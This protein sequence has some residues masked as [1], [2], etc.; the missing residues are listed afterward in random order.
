MT[1]LHI[2]SL[3][4]LALLLLLVEPHSPSTTKAAI[5]RVATL[6]T[7][8]AAHT[9]TTLPSGHVLFVGGMVSGGSSGATAE[10]FDPTTNSVEAV[11]S[12]AESRAGHT[13]TQL[14]NGKVLVAGGYN[15]DY[16][17]SIELFDPSTRRFTPAGS[18]T[19]A[20][21]GHTATLL[22]DGRVLF[23][24][25]VGTGWTF[26]RSAEIYDA[27]LG[28]SQPVGSM[29][30]PR[31]SHT[32]TLL[33][34]GR[35]LIVGGH[36]GRRQN[37]IVYTSAEAFSPETR[38]FSAAGEL[39]IARHKH[40]AVRLKDGRVLIVAG[41]DRTDRNHFN[42]TEIYDPKA[43]TFENGPSMANRRYKIAGTTVL[44]PNGD[45]LVTSG[46]PNAEIFSSASKTFA[47]VPGRF[48]A[49]YRFAAATALKGGDVIIAGGY[50]DANANTDGIWRFRP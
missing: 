39:A 12:L 16:V 30:A 43:A 48:P 35:V 21:S 27:S 8:R 32:A 41:A 28:T 22:P 5:E 42:T 2:Q 9:A 15:G 29:S 3:G 6:R 34:D 50:S 17:A 46:G 25:G 38:R 47:A 37:M 20:R 45:V 13:A 36:S 49:A 10:L 23:V 24:G 33:V 4:A 19:E 18:M 11:A 1:P 14:P 26:L 44:L 7:P 31:E 40:D